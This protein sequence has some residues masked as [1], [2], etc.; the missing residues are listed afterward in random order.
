[1]TRYE[2]YI[3]LGSSVLMY[4]SMC[5]TYVYFVCCWFSLFL[6][7]FCSLAFLALRNFQVPKEPHLY[8][9]IFWSTIANLDLKLEFTKSS[10]NLF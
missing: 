2:K 3:Y 4:M 9:K 7:F 10:Q 1:M 5:V 6:A 8:E